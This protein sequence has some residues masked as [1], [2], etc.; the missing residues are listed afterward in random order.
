MCVM[1][2]LNFDSDGVAFATDWKAKVTPATEWW[3]FGCVGHDLYS[4]D[5]TYALFP[6]SGHKKSRVWISNQLRDRVPYST[7]RCD[8]LLKYF[9]LNPCD[10][11]SGETTLKL[12]Q[13]RLMGA[14]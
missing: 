3:A 13:S 7:F 2:L 1:F 11:I 9:E 12:F 14:Q 5:L 8:L 6:S 10:R 4:V